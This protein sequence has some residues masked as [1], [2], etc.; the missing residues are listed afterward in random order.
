[1]T[2]LFIIMND[3]FSLLVKTLTYGSQSELFRINL[4]E[5]KMPKS[6][7]K[8]TKS[9]NSK[10]QK[11]SKINKKNTSKITKNAKKNEKNPK[12]QIHPKSSKAEPLKLRKGLKPQ[13]SA[14]QL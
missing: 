11:N 6:T 3:S 1:M 2:H 13:W 8:N 10:I 7:T 5:R 4:I 14:F 12:N 9:Q